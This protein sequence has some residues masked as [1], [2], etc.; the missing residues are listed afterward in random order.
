[1]F[2]YLKDYNDV[3]GSITC[4]V[5]LKNNKY[6]EHGLVQSSYVFK[7][8]KFL[9]LMTGHA[10]TA[11][12]PKVVK[13]T[14][15]FGSMQ[16]TKGSVSKEFIIDYIGKHIG[17]F[18]DNALPGTNRNNVIFD[19]EPV[20]HPESGT[21]EVSFSI[22][23]YLDASGRVVDSSDG[24]APLPSGTFTLSG[25]NTAGLTTTVDSGHLNNVGTI[26]ADMVQ[27]DAAAKTQ[28]LNAIIASGYIKGVANNGHI[29]LG[30]LAIKE[31]TKADNVTL[32]RLLLL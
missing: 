23:R 22:N 4:D 3:E 14:A 8:K 13:D 20:Y 11:K 30:D 5:T 19:S 10:T 1:M 31:V 17:S 24:F 2:H 6:W 21:I 18:Y 29:E 16:A 26:Q 32:V 12:T 25:F 15:A 9:G 28:V 27:Y 7:N